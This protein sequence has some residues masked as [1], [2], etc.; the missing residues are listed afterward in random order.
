MKCPKCGK[1]MKIDEKN[2]RYICK[3]GKIIKWGAQEYE[4]NNQ[5]V[6]VK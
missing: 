3:C 5:E 6:S 4:E 2:E 1:H